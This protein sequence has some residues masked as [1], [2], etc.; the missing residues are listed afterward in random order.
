MTSDRGRDRGHGRADTGRGT[1]EGSPATGTAS[2]GRGGS[3]ATDD[4]TKGTIDKVVEKLDAKAEKL[5]RVA[6]KMTKKAD[7]LDRVAKKTAAKAE[8]L[9]RIG[10]GLG[11][12]D[13]WTR[14]EP[15]PRRPRFTRDDITAAAVRIADA[16]GFDALSMRKLATE[17]DAGT[18]TLY[19]YVRTKDELLT[20]AVDA[21]MSEVVLGPDDSMPTH[22]RDALVMLAER[23]RASI[24]RHQWIL[25]LID[26]PGIGP[27]S[28]RHFDETLEAVASLDLDLSEK[29]DITSLVDQY[30][31][32]WC[33][34]ER[35]AQNAAAVYSG[36]DRAMLD[37][38]ARLVDTGDYPQ[39]AA[40]RDQYGLEDAWGRIQE[41]HRDATRFRR[42][43]DLLLDGIE[44]NL[45][46]RGVRVSTSAG[47]G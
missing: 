44:A 39:L 41:H 37:Y 20:L 22:W 1:R 7:K 4:R 29:L 12:F 31:F 17:L 14:A 46:R 10:E 43:L 18:M 16:E 11:R 21:V 27:N 47:S 3:R 15:T 26:D 33:A 9:E 24:I 34:F 38:V 13:L 23:S 30:V 45:E 8:V 28:V 32:G 19:H 35:E 2:R 6:A 5:D 40:L 36:V 25:D 42:N